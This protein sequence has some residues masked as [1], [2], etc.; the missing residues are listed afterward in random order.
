MVVALSRCWI[1]ATATVTNFTSCTFNREGY[2]FKGHCIFWSWSFCDGQLG[3]NQELS[4]IAI[5]S[6][7]KL[8]DGSMLI[9]DKVLYGVCGKIGSL[10]MR[11]EVRTYEDSDNQNEVMKIKTTGFEFS[12]MYNNDSLEKVVKMV[13][14]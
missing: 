3:N 11:G 13:L 6:S 1:D 14:Q 10:D 12:Y 5:N 2:I 7:K 8:G 4:N 9:S